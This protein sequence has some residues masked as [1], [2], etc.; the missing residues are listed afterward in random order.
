M[1]NTEIISVAAINENRVL[2]DGKN[3]PWDVKEDKKHYKRCVKGKPLIV[4]RKTFENSKAHIFGEKVFLMTRNEDYQTGKNNV[5]IFN[6]VQELIE[7][8]NKS[9]YN[10]VY[11][12]GGGQIYNSFLEYTDTIVLSEINNKSDGKVKF[13]KLEEKNWKEIHTEKYNNFKVK[14]IIRVR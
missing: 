2:G 12:I 9:E 1:K 4:G 11:N 7:H 6:T 3:I 10:R 8:L 13:P 5:K 14:Y